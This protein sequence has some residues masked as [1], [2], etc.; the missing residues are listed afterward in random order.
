MRNNKWTSRP[1]TFSP[2]VIIKVLTPGCQK[3]YQREGQVSC[4]PRTTTRDCKTR[5]ICWRI[6]ALRSARSRLL[7]G[8]HVVVAVVKKDEFPI[9]QRV[10]ILSSSSSQMSPM[11][12]VRG[13]V[14]ASRLRPRGKVEAEAAWQ[15]PKP[16]KQVTNQKGQLDRLNSSKF[17]SS[18]IRS[19]PAFPQR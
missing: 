9:R 8:R 17:K 18:L 10:E 15:E 5:P 14:P 11:R 13:D 2:K 16:A 19:W 7:W 6:H 1:I 12:R 4:P 3:T